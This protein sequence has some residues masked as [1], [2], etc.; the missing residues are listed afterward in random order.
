MLHYTR[1]EAKR[2]GHKLAHPNEMVSKLR[3]KWHHDANFRL[4]T[5]LLV[6]SAVWAVHLMVVYPL[7]SLTCRWGWFGTTEADAQL[8]IV[9]TVAT[10]VAAGLIAWF[11]YVA[12]QT[13]LQSRHAGHTEL[14]EAETARITMQAFVTLLLNALYFLIILIMLAPIFVLPLCRP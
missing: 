9:Q 4:W 3:H 8:R 14:S 1:V 12:F 2:I 6:G 10:L 7:A 5:C 13:W 11:G